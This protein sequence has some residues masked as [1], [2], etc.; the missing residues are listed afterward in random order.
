MSLMSKIITTIGAGTLAITVAL[1]LTPMKADAATIHA[2]SAKIIVDGPRGTADGR[3]KIE[4]A[5]GEADGDFFELGYDAVVEFQFGNPSGQLFFGPGSL[6]EIT[7]NNNPNWKEAVRIE[8]GMKG[9]A[10][11]F[12]TAEPNPFVNISTSGNPVFSFKGIFDTVRLTDLTMA[13]FGDDFTNASTQLS[14]GGFDVDSISVTAVPLPAAGF[15]L[16][17]ALGGLAALRRRRKAA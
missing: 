7:F 8:V 1:A 5:F 9:D 15:L 2:T 10:G 11:S 4:N 17:G 3:D 13:L 14:T 6:L 16:V 12:K